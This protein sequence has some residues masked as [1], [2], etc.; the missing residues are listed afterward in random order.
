MLGTAEVT[1]AVAR[2][3]T[4]C[5]PARPVVVDPVM[6][7]ESGARLLDARRPA[8][9]RARRSC[10]ARPCSRRTCPRRGCSSAREL[11][12]RRRDE[13]AE[14]EALARAVLALGPRVVVL[15]GGHRARAVDLFLDSDGRRVGGEHRG[16]APPRRRRARLRLHALLGA[17]R[18]AGP[19]PHAA[20][21]P[22]APP[23]RSRERR[24]RTGC[25]TSARA[26]ARSTSLG[27]RRGCARDRE[28]RAPRPFAII[29]G[30]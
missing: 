3:S 28:R 5:P 15:T 29:G 14:A 23:A 8:R 22:R 2:R 30:R 12:A 11:G 20:A 21:R 10:R 26:P 9:A 4:S 1:L 6:V 19:R 24:S 18:P 16:R 7:A 13:D 27:P 17:R 25:A